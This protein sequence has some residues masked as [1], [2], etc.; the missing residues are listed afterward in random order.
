MA[1]GAGGA[2]ILVTI[3]RQAMAPVAMGLVAGLAASLAAGR[4]LAGLLYGVTAAD[5]TTIV[6]VMLTLGAAAAAASVIP[7]WRATRVDPL[8]ALRY[9]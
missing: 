7:A 4:L 1:L 6:S 3:V 2:D 8:T 5:A 9:E